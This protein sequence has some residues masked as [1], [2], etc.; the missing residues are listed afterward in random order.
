MDIA[1]AAM[2]DVGNVT[3]SAA[4]MN[5]PDLLAEL[6]AITGGAPPAQPK[7][8]P[9][10]N[11]EAQIA[12]KKKEALAAKRAGDMPAAKALLS[13][14]KALE[15]QLVRQQPPPP[16]AAAA[17]SQQAPLEVNEMDALRLASS[18]GEGDVKVTMSDADMLDPE[19]L[20]ELA[21]VT[22][23]MEPPPAEPARPSRRELEG[24]IA[25]A[26][27]Q[28]LEAKRSGDKATAV[29]KLKE[30]KQLEA[31]L[32]AFG[33]APP[34]PSAAQPDATAAALAAA[35]AAVAV[36]DG[37]DG[38]DG[39]Y[40]DEDDEEGALAALVSS[41]GGS[42][43]SSKAAAPGRG[44]ASTADDDEMAALV[45][46]M[47][48]APGATSAGAR[49]ASCSADD[50]VAL[51]ALV[52]SMSS[53]AP[54]GGGSAKG[55]GSG[56]DGAP[57][58][59]AAQRQALESDTAQ[60]LLD[61]GLPVS[62]VLEALGFE[63]PL[64]SAETEPVAAAE[65][66]AAA[67]PPPATQKRAALPPGMP[68][69]SAPPAADGAEG[70]AQRARQLK[71]EALRLK[72]AGDA[73]GA[74]AKLKEAKALE[75]GATAAAST[76]AP[77]SVPAPASAA[78]PVAAALAAAA[79]AM[80]VGDDDDMDDDDE[81]AAGG[82][83]KAEAPERD[84]HDVADRALV[85]AMD[86]GEWRAIEAAVA[87]H[88]ANA[89]ADILGL[90]R[91]KAAKLK[92]ADA[93]ASGTAAQK[94]GDV[95]GGG[96]V[97]AAR[98]LALKRE[99]MALKN[100]GD[101]AGAVAKL[102]EAKELEAGAASSAGGGGGV[103]G[104]DIDLKIVGGRGL[105]AKDHPMWGKPSSDP[106]VKVQLHEVGA[107]QRTLKIGSTTKLSKTLE[108]VWNEPFAF[109]VDAAQLQTLELVLAL[110]DKDNLSKDDPMG[111]VRVALT[112]LKSGAT[113]DRWLKVKNCAG[114]DDASG[115]LHIQ[116]TLTHRSG[117]SAARDRDASA[118]DGTSSDRR[119][120]RAPSVS[121]GGGGFAAPLPPET[122]L[123]L[124]ALELR[125][126]SAKLPPQDTPPTTF[127]VFSWEL[128]GASAETAR[129]QSVK[130]SQT[131]T[132]NLV[133]RFT[134]DRKRKA[135]LSFFKFKRCVI[136][137]MAEPQSWFGGEDTLLGRAEF[138]LRPL[139]T[140][141]KWQG[142]VPLKLDGVFNEA[143]NLMTLGSLTVQ[144][145]LRCGL[146]EEPAPAPAA[147]P[148]PRA[149]TS[150][151]GPAKPSP[152]TAP[153][154]TAAPS[155]KGASPAA[156]AEEE[157]DDFQF[158]NR[159]VSL[160]VLMWELTRLKERMDALA[161]KGQIVPK[162]YG[163]RIQALEFRKD[164]LQLQAENGL[165][166]PEAYLQQLRTAIPAEKKRA[167]AAK[168][169]GNKGKAMEALKHAK[170]MEAELQA[171]IAGGMG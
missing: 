3:L 76:A 157:E 78:D 36:V 145:R 23:G 43:G 84:P 89:S 46:S 80:A 1:N 159:I 92:A 10:P 44:R 83:D 127:A 107:E 128:E 66:E 94:R 64:P 155:K 14:A 57:E 137:V 119:S 15:A 88:G 136:D 8:A 160:E 131:P 87:E 130:R 79:A 147:A 95:V 140:E 31:E 143:G 171:A 39:G 51:S 98:V 162:G 25:A 12:A 139:L 97:A 74:V 47:S 50:D 115:E 28:A 122:E 53:N 90:V 150:G 21:A 63:A 11:L 13:Q 103:L 29:A 54:G 2:Q 167:L 38:G 58:L 105:V 37:M 118:S 144:V 34:Q 151:G 99:A 111:Q 123:P 4:E 86:S 81:M 134:F 161:A 138:K 56:G 156:A 110:F 141:S 62:E 114:C 152:T 27:A 73:A 93:S 91:G 60:M 33:S 112:G 68:P 77:A 67:A 132:W 100:A 169:A 129:T 133:E 117:A 52:A 40:G 102:R 65:T 149:S 154:A 106:Y 164:M 126:I 6:A 5:D 113:L 153:A 72:K 16:A 70:V 20:A 168:S 165:L 125:I 7:S 41:M 148:A 22:G 71:A 82:M 146:E 61:S 69:G 19:L 45:A 121:D 166:T 163:D 109:S 85:R 17:P 158:A 49:S 9:V 96:G 135:T 75:A 35:A 170:V 124:N 101:R 42:G 116:L 59:T 24:R 55:D 48:S 30:A 18:A 32:Q 104:A 120:C 108:P 26:K 142:D